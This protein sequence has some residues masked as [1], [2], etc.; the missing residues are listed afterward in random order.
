MIWY[1]FVKA[2]AFLINGL[3]FI[4]PSGWTVDTLPFGTDAYF[5]T[6]FGGLYMLASW[7]PPLYTMLQVVILYLIFLGGLQVIKMLMAH[8]SPLH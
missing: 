7:L 5:S 3:S 8:R 6:G 2:F 4:T 1:L